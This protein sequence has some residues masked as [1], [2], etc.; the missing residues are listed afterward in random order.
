MKATRLPNGSAER[1]FSA[2][3]CMT[4]FNLEVWKTQQQSLFAIHLAKAKKKIEHK[5]KSKAKKEQLHVVNE[6]EAIRAKLDQA[7]EALQEAQREQLQRGELLDARERAMEER[8]LHLSS[9]QEQLVVQLESENQRVRE[10]YQVMIEGL[11]EQVREKD[12]HIVALRD[13]LRISEESYERLRRRVLVARANKI[14]DEQ[15]EEE[16]EDW[17]STPDGANTRL[18]VLEQK[19]KNEEEKGET[20]R[21]G[22]EKRGRKV[23][24]DGLLYKDIITGTSQKYKQRI[25]QLQNELV[26]SHATIQDLNQVIRK[27]RE[28]NAK[29]SEES[30][31]SL[32]ALR[33]REEQLLQQARQCEWLQ[34]VLKEKEKAALEGQQ[35]ELSRRERGL[36]IREIELANT[37]G[38]VPGAWHRSPLSSASYPSAISR[39]DLISAYAKATNPTRCSATLYP[40]PVPSSSPLVFTDPGGVWTTDAVGAIS[41]LRRELEGH[42]QRSSSSK[43]LPPPYPPSQ[44]PCV[45]AEANPSCVSR[46]KKR[47]CKKDL[48][49]SPSSTASSSLSTVSQHSPSCISHAGWNEEGGHEEGCGS[50]PSKIPHGAQCGNLSM[51][52]PASDPTA[53]QHRALHSTEGSGLQG[54]EPPSVHSGIPCRS[55]EEKK[56][57][58]EAFTVVPPPHSLQDTFHGSG[59]STSSFLPRGADDVSTPLHRTDPRLEKYKD[60]PIVISPVPEEFIQASRVSS[61][62]SST[63]ATEMREFVQQLKMNRQRLLE[64]QVY[65]EEHPIL[66]E[67]SAKL[68]LYE[69]Y[70][71]QHE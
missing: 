62:Q 60:G 39:T 20:I 50:S 44:Q 48:P 4:D 32:S 11:R 18:A 64:T 35:Q 9:K 21:G 49:Q 40:P 53:L 16:E 54:V 25:H 14:V 71:Q 29:A 56:T 47:E 28:A 2:E 65:T 63:V 31:A 42:R 52:S 7:S 59:A 6:L 66:Q 13:R 43:V 19:E 10:R 67:M 69:E 8:R 68:K 5:I 1:L 24:Q 38:T 51:A 57:P 61:V 17:D 33:Q 12:H 55:G 41:G 37:L 26:F 34:Q 46:K 23:D 22:K 15:E 3:E 70:L 45:L 58:Q 27:E 36:H 30:R